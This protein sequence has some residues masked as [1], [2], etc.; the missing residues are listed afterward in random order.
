GANMPGYLDA[1]VGGWSFNGGG[2]IQAS[3][4]D[5]GAVRLVGMSK[6]DL[7]KMYK[8]DIRIDPAT[9]LKTVYLLPDE[10]IL[11]TRRAFSTSPSTIDGYSTTLGAP[12]GRY[13]APASSENCV[14]VHG[15][16]CTDRT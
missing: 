6:K 13:I 14:E 9:G 8:H 1:I 2:R 4:V 3:M 12:P 16:E 10:I 5:F 7:Q 15:G 11:N